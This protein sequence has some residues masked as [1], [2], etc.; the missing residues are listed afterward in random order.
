MNGKPQPRRVLFVSRQR[1]IGATNGSS[2]YLLELAGALRAA[3]LSPHLLQ[4]SP[5][6]MGRMPVMRLLPE[7][8]V[9]ASHRIRG[10]VR[11]GSRVISIDWRVYAAVARAIVASGARRLGLTAAWTRDKPLPYSIAIPWTDADRAYVRRHTAKYAVVIADYMFQAEAFASLAEPEVPTAIVMHDLFH[12]RA[13]DDAAGRNR[14][15]VERVSRG[16]EIAM[17]QRADAVIAIQAAEATFVTEQVPGTR[18]ILAPMAASA[19]RAAAP[20]APD[21]LLFVGSN[22]APNV[23]GLAWLFEHVW[24]AVHVARPD[25][26]LDIAGSVSRAFPDG[27][28]PGVRFHGIVE[29]LAPLYEEAGVV[30]SPLTFG[31]GLKI[32]LIEALAHGKAMVVTP[33]TLQGVEAEVADAVRLTDDPRLFARHIIDLLADDAARGALATRA[34]SVA[35]RHFTADAAY[36]EFVRWV[37]TAQPRTARVTAG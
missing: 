18:A 20:G 2:T 34:L 9:F 19:A 13:A 15:S 23:V 6:I 14:D 30:L 21:R 17:L 8:S 35:K 27:G 22:T 32:K 10:V 1:L 3:G 16:D 12:S 5:T 26:R 29:D 11:V 7:M 37:E 24:P 25:V 31:S 4:P 33:V 28:P 36:G